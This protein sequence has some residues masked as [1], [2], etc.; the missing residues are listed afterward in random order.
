MSAAAAAT[1]RGDFI[2]IDGPDG[3]GKTTQS[4]R[5]AR[6]LG[7]DRPVHLTREPGGTWLGE[8]IRDLLLAGT[9]PASPTDPITDALLFNAARRQLVRELIRPALASGTTVI[10]ARFADS[11]VA[12]QGHGAGVPLA[13]LAVLE[14]A[15]TDG[16]R[17]DLTILLDLPVEVGLGR[18]APDDLTRFESDYDLDF[19]R[20]VRAGFLSIAA[21]EPG[22]VVV[23]DATSDEDDVAAE[24]AAAVDR[25]LARG[26]P[27][28]ERTRIPG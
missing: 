2:T 12:Y 25:W 10:C 26:E 17:P 16:L 21:A 18:K 7:A 23:V 8:R 19:H 20:R 6:H 15:A 11:T 4:Q 1:A 3:G 5:L 28:G 27:S 14:A 22:R 24:I 13:T 9:D